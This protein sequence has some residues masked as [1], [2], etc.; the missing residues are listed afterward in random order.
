[1]NF[2]FGEG[3]GFYLTDFATDELQPY[4]IEMQLVM[5]LLQIGLVGLIF[6]MSFFYYFF[7]LVVPDHFKKAF[8][9]FCLI[10]I[11]NPWLFLPSWLITATYFYKL[12]YNE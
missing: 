7:Y 5:L 8:F 4:Q 3:F 6:L 2:L 9:L 12:K 1:M 11:V 10:G